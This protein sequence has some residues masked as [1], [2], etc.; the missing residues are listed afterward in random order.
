MWPFSKKWNPPEPQMAM[1]IS[2]AKEEL[3]SII[4]LANPTGADGAVAGMAGPADGKPTGENMLRPMQEGQYVAI[5]P[6]GGGCSVRVERAEPG[7]Q[8]LDLAPETFEA[9]GLTEEMLAKFNR[10]A[11]RV[12][13]EMAAPGKEVPET[14]VFVA[15][16]AQRL[17]VLGDGVVMDT[18]AYRFFGPGGLAGGKSD[19][20]IRCA[21]TCPYPYRVGFALVSYARVDQV[22]PARNGNL[23]RAGGTGAHRLRDAAGHCAVCDHVGGHRAGANVRRPEPAFFRARREEEPGTLERP[24]CTGVG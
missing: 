16:L 22:R 24:P 8:G 14:V 3:P 17:A 21:G 20:G 6:G 7:A 11:W 2:L 12:I 13:L 18:A 4:M 19:C 23:W 9:S 1:V 10:P 15:R 5:S